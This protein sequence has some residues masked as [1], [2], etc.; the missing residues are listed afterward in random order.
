MLEETLRGR[1]NDLV[2]AMILTQGIVD[3]AADAIITISEEGTM[4]S[5]N[6]AAREMFGYSENEVLAR[7]VSMLMPPPYQDEHDGYLKSYQQ[8]G[9]K[10]V[11]GMGREVI[12]QRKDG[13]VFPIDLAVSEVQM[14]TRRVFTGIVRDISKRKKAEADLVEAKDQAIEAVRMKSEFLA[15]MS[16]EIERP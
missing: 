5:F 4:E 1:E 6:K 9:E 7:N 3:T 2:D 13:M 14:G 8:T 16:H 12:G 15:M 11:I 10:K